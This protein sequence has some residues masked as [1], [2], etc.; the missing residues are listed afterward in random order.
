ML[1]S[2]KN[3]NRYD[4][5]KDS[6]IEWIGEIPDSWNVKRLKVLAS[7]QT[8]NTPPKENSSENYYAEQGF[9]WV[10]PD[11]LD[12]F[13]PIKTTN[14]YL[15]NEGIKIA[16]VVPAN[17]PLICCIG[18]IGKF[19][20]SNKSVAFNQQ[21]NAILFK[22]E[23]V[24]TRF[25]L[26]YLS[27]QE[28]QH[29]FYSNGNV[30]KILNAQ[31]QGKICCTCPSMSEQEAIAGYLDR[32][33]GA[34]DETIE[35]Q[36]SVIEKLKEYK[37]SIITQAVTKGLDKSAPM[38]DSGIEWIGQIPQHWDSIKLKFCSYIRAR[39]G[40]KG[41]KAEEYVEEGYPLLS[42]FNIVN[43]KL[44]FENL[45]FINQFRYDESPEIKLQTNDI[46][47]VKDGA[48]IGKCAIV[49]NMPIPSTANG[50]L[51][52]ISTN[53]RLVAKFLYYYFISTIFQ[54]YIDRLKD[55]MGVPHL[56][57]ADLKEI[58]IVLPKE[59]E[60][61]NIVEFLDKK[62]SE[63]DKNIEDKEKLIEK[64]VEYKKSLIYECVTGKRKVVA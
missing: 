31:N 5:Y 60:Q 18:S 28:E 30:V 51:A 19:G 11:N 10:K 4:K 46:L 54:A 33:C 47:L 40:W 2:Q 22:K 21:I 13:N 44:I 38:K 1:D 49:E 42:A 6:G 8:G 39:L 17:T 24:N 62:C 41:L 14:E 35:K 52:V 59:Q 58:Q 25:G 36:K 48:G 43:S 37:Q 26:Y 55:G 9:L 27:S 16:R 61:K 64:L 56:F 45:N 29:W 57:Q 20:V 23:L 63:I 3:S 50:S 7:I 34:I 12:N 32:K 53:Y 15:N